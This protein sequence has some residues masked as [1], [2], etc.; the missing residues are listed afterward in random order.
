MSVPYL[1]T[2]WVGKLY[3]I[4]SFFLVPLFTNSCL[5]AL[6]NFLISQGIGCSKMCVAVKLVYTAAQCVLGSLHFPVFS[7][8]YICMMMNW[9][10]LLY[11]FD[12]AIDLSLRV[13]VCVCVYGWAPVRTKG[14]KPILR[15]FFGSIPIRHCLSMGNEYKDWR[16]KKRKRENK[17][18]REQVHYN[19]NPIEW[20]RQTPC[21]DQWVRPSQI[22]SVVQ[23]HTH[24]LE[25]EILIYLFRLQLQ[26]KK[27]NQ[28]VGGNER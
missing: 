6:F 25:P 1:T 24:T 16:K 21:H 15:H 11:S 5:I 27:Q 13:C 20:Q 7:H 4:H 18:K 28:R 9:L 2:I 3:I 23:T 17:M 22:H 12:K 14:K 10:S 26:K 8:L 19:E